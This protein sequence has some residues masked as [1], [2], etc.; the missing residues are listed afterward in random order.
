M[1]GSIDLTHPNVTN[2][3]EKIIVHEKYDHKTNGINDIALLKV[4]KIQNFSFWNSV[5]FFF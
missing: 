3:V 1:A 5:V 4:S 2:L